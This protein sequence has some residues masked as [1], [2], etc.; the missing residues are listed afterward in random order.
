MGISAPSDSRPDSRHRTI[1]IRP[2]VPALITAGAAIVIAL[3]ATNVILAFHNVR[4]IK[5]NAARLSQTQQTV[6]SLN[7]LLSLA[8][9]AETGQRGFIITGNPEYLDPYNTAITALADEVATV[10]R[11]TQDSPDQ[12]TRLLAAQARLNAK[13]SELD[14]TITLRRTQGFEAAQRVV[15]TDQGKQEMDALRGVIDQ[16]VEAA[17]SQLRVQFQ[18]SA[19]TYRA[20]ATTGL[21]LGLS[22]ITAFIAYAWLLRRYFNSRIQAAE[23]LAQQANQ[24]KTT[25]ASIG[26][27]VI[28]TDDQ[29]V[30]TNL[31]PVAESLSGW[32]ASEAIGQPLDEVFRIINEDTRQSVA[33]PAHK[34]LTKGIVVG[35]ANHTLLIDKAGT[36]RPIDDSAAPIQDSSGKVLGCVLVFRDVTERQEQARRLRASQRQFEQIADTMPQMVWVTRPDGYCEY[37]NRRW[38]EYFGTT[39]EEALGY[40]WSNALHPDDV[41]ITQ[42]RWNTSLRTGNPYEV[43]YRFRAKTGEYRWFLNRAHPVRDQAGEITQWFGTC[44]DIEELKQAQKERDSFV[45]LANNALDFISMSDR[46]GK[47]F[48]INPAGKNKIGLSDSREQNA[49]AMGDLFFAEDR[50]RMLS[51]FL[52]L[53]WATGTGTTDVRLQPLTSADP[54]W[55]RFSATVI[56]NDQGQLAGLAVISQDMS[57]RR[58]LEDDLRQTASALAEANRRKDEFLATLAHE[59]RNPLAPIRNGLQVMYQS[60][61][62]PERIEQIRA[63]MKRQLTQM[64]RLVDDLLDVSRIS[65]GRFELSKEKVELAAIIE[66]AVETSQPAIEAAKHDLIVALPPQPI[67][68]YA[69]AVRLVQVFSNLINNA[70]KYSDPGGTITISARKSEEVAEEVV[71]SVKDT[72]IGIAPDML[73]KIFDMFTQ[74]EGALARS[75]GGLG[76]GLTLVKHLVERHQGSVEA[77]SLGIGKGSEFTVRLPTVEGIEAPLPEVD[78]PEEV[79]GDRRILIVDD[80]EDSALTL[81]MLFEMTGDRTQTAYDGL[82]AV[83][84]AETFRPHIVLLDIGLPKLN[85]YEVARQIRQQPWGQKMVLIALTGWGQPEDRR[86][87]SEAGFDGHL[88]KPI[89]HDTLLKLVDELTCRS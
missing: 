70:S 55:M 1:A 89:D 11:L 51:K 4:Q 71:I 8:K 26:D 83:A 35:L 82:A 57:E 53:V 59:L 69:D 15:S 58:Q 39:S 36:E 44:T 74:V 56:K 31:N 65:R 86:K 49:I 76:I 80:N 19:S 47:L 52:P 54:I 64:V 10:D 30:I 63:M 22:A 14:R 23:L 6:N 17:Q 87:S 79:E 67:Y 62:N 68:L 37:F 18:D 77:T 42:E 9:D 16:M 24:L 60:P 78:E 25:I 12:Q 88:V 81:E 21:L 2:Q 41:K 3:F 13:L 5:T 28:T 40:S 50:D 38:Y 29:G 66:Q 85:G 45:R 84:T 46:E 7:N 43:E 48:Y 73:P 61:N 27:G 75:Q 33:N 20:A 34:A 32:T 72:G